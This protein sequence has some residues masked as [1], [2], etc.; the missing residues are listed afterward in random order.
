MKFVMALAALGLLAAFLGI[1]VWHVPEPDLI[2]VVTIVTLFAGYD[3][4]SSL[5]KSKD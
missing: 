3:F 5:L 4:V 1:L 2:A